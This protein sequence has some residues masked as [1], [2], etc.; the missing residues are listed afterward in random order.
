MSELNLLCEREGIAFYSYN[1]SI[2]RLY[3]DCYQGEDTPPYFSRLTHRI[4]MLR[5]LIRSG[6]TVVYMKKGEDTLGHLV[7]SRGGSRVAVSDREDI[8]I[9][10]IWV[11][12]RH[13]GEG[14]GTIGIRMI[15]EYPQ[16]IYRYAYEFIE[17][18][19]IASIKTV[20]KNGFCLMFRCSESGL[21]RT[22]RRDEE[23]KW[24]LYRYE[25]DKI[26]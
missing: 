21:M 4:R 24:L 2:F 10:P 18:N 23:G 3:D 22:L 13:R 11:V 17:D 9:G 1:P 6:Y 7:V 16:F 12:P 5:E 26:R 8:L 19:N 20:E 25:S 15:L 14:L